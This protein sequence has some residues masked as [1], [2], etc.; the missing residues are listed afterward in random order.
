MVLVPG[1]NMK[2]VKGPTFGFVD[3]V[4]LNPG[5]TTGAADAGDAATSTTAAASS[6]VVNGPMSSRLRLIAHSSP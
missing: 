3:F 1:T 2:F 5:L 6:A 4:T